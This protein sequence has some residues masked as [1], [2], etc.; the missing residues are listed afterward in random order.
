MCLLM[1]I[2]RESGRDMTDAPCA[3]SVGLDVQSLVSRI[4]YVGEDI[5]EKINADAGSVSD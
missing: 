2:A 5:T 1:C 4:P 3:I